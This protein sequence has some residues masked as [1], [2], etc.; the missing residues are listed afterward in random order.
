MGAA[1]GLLKGNQLAFGFLPAL[2]NLM[3]FA[4]VRGPQSGAFRKPV[5]IALQALQALLAK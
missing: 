2:H 1:N 4:C 5:P 3:I